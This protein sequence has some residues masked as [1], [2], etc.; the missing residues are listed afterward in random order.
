SVQSRL[1]HH[2]CRCTDTPRPLRRG[3]AAGA[4]AGRP[5]RQRCPAVH[6]LLA[7]MYFHAARFDARV[8]LDGSIVLFEQQDR[9]TWKWSDVR[10]G[11]AWLVRSAAGNELTRYYVEA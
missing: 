11:M 5:S 6:A 2:S 9:S 4:D 7:L 1:P 3:P 8:T 10:E